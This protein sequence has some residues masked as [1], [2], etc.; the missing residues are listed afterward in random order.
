MCVYEEDLISDRKNISKVLILEYQEDNNYSYCVGV[1]EGNVESI[2]K[3]DGNILVKI[4]S[5][6]ITA[7]KYNNEKE[8]KDEYS[9]IH[10]AIKSDINNIK[11]RIE[12]KHEKKYK[13]QLLDSNG[14]NLNNTKK[15]IEKINKKIDEKNKKPN[16][17]YKE[18]MKSIDE[19]EGNLRP[20]AQ[21]SKY[22][23]RVI[24]KGDIEG[25]RTEFQRDWE[26][27]IHAKSFRRLEDK[28]QIYTLSKGDHFRTRLTHTLEVTQIARGISREL[29]LNEDLVEAIALGHDLGHTPFGHVGERTLNEILQNEGVKGGFK[30]NFQGVRVVNYLEEKYGEFEGIDLTYQVIEGILKHTKVCS[31][32]E[33]CSDKIKG[34]KCSKNIFKLKAFLCNGD[35]KML[36]PEFKFATT[37]EGQVVAVADEI[38]QRAHDLDDG[39]ASGIINEDKFLTE[40][41][42]IATKEFIKRLE[43]EITKSIYESGNLSK[44]EIKEQ[45]KRNLKNIA[46][47][48]VLRGL[49]Q[50]RQKEFLDIIKPKE[51]YNKDN[52]TKNIEKKVKDFNEKEALNKD[53][54]KYELYNRICKSLDYID[55]NQR[56]YI[57]EL[58]IK[59]ARIVSDVISYFIA[60]IRD[61]S[62]KRIKNY[63]NNH[64]KELE[65]N[66]FIKEELIKFSAQTEK[67]RKELEKISSNKIINSEEV[68]CFDGKGKYVIRKIY[69]AYKTNPMQ[70]SKTTLKRIFREVCKYTNYVVDIT[71]SDYSRDDIEKEIVI[72]SG[73]DNNNDINIIKH[74]IFGRCLV[75]LISGMTDDFANRQ[76]DKLY[77]PRIY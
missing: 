71:D 5:I 74:K 18:I 34:L 68:N 1:A 72:Y 56:D 25:N 15:C 13:L 31:C 27:I 20:S 43:I 63:E 61:D 30:H 46:R 67:V 9:K 17:K 55:E 50:K 37:L 7:I 76:Y 28:A 57:D 22:V 47:R 45:I 77:S 32:K 40:L 49:S 54:F 16:E 53:D 44:E 21:R 51:I 65:E 70:M 39:I 19:L 48:N 4:T 6:E 12:F 11:E 23:E 58:D 66:L 69:N 62:E 14:L 29:N 75:D 33:K 52:F 38:A 59:R 3:I 41:K 26:R 8:I 73:E 2:E 36:H 42:Q 64:K 24:N 60:K 10:D 35:I